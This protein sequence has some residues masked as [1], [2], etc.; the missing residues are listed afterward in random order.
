LIKEEWFTNGDL[1]VRYRSYFKGRRAKH[2][3]DLEM[4]DTIIALAATAVYFCP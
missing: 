2:E 3:D 4:P 1:A